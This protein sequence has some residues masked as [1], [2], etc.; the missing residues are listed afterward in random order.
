MRPL[1]AGALPA[2]HGKKSVLTVVRRIPIDMSAK[3][4][5]TKSKQTIHGT[6]RGLGA[7]FSRRRTLRLLGFVLPFISFARRFRVV[8]STLITQK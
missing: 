1:P 3:R 5:D 7:V 8:M 6:V 4:K 2:D